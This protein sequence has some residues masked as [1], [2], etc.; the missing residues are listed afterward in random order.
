[1]LFFSAND[2]VN[3]RELWKLDNSVTGIA[4]ESFKNNV[5]VYPN[6]ANGK[7]TVRLNDKKENVF[8]KIFNALGEM[9]YSDKIIDEK[10]VIE[11]QNK[12]KG[13][14]LIEMSSQSLNET[15]KLII[16]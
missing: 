5:S 4:S 1:M 13:I 8:L 6:P 15:C 2:G 10:I 3:G 7:F 11:L 9:I 12:P 16:E 14:Y